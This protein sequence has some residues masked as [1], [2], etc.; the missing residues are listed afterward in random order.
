M[1]TTWQSII[2]SAINT[3]RFLHQHPE[4]SW[5]ENNTAEVIRNQLTKL[6]IQWRE[7]ANTGTLAYLNF[8]STT[9]S[10]TIALRGDIDA[11]PID[12]A[13]NLNWQ[14]KTSGCMHACGHDGHCA[15]LLAS[16]HW[17]KLNEHK[18]NCRVVLIFQPAE[19]GGHGAREMINDGALE[20]VDEIFG[21]HNW[22]AIPFGQLLC[23]DG[24]VMCGNGTFEIT[25]KG[26]GGHASQPEL[27]QDPVLAASAVTLALQQIVSRRIAPQ[28]TA[29]VSVTSIEA[30]S[31]ATVIPQQAVLSGCIRVPDET[32]KAQV[33]EL[34]K[35][36]SEQT[37]ASYGTRAEVKIFPRYQATINHPQ[38]AS[39]VRSNWQTL[40][41]QD[42][43]ASSIATPI[44]ASEDF[45]YYLSEIPGAFALI[46]ADDGEG[47]KAPC[48]NPEYDFNDKLIEKVCH[49]Y[50]SL[51]G[52]NGR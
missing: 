35:E 40:F 13:T 41:G 27:C 21:W 43:L 38:Q 23:P 39:T 37:A 34:I 29:V 19:E 15:T 49:L 24:I 9:T 6:G 11:L 46:G 26:T 44:M 45:S 33:N 14:S 50:A 3:R 30:Q 12:E 31:G 20:G 32:I 52:I 51:V 48:H 25:I 5:R 16:A 42:S 17:L 1:S 2:D 7:C 47:H 4:L 10:K 36:I 28:Q 22:P 8:E 18:L